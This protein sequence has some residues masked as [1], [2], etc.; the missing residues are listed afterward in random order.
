VA[1]LNPGTWMGIAISRVRL[2][3]SRV[4]IIHNSVV[5]AQHISQICPTLTAELNLGTQVAIAILSVLLQL[6]RVCII[7]NS[8]A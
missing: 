4:H 3:L 1:E 6:G 5:N 8:V 2:Q 7:H